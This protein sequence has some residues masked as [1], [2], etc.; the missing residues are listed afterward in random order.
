MLLR[1]IERRSQ[2]F[3]RNE[4]EADTPISVRVMAKWKLRAY[5]NGRYVVIVLRSAGCLQLTVQ[6]DKIVHDLERGYRLQLYD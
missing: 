2:V 6:A 4:A 1:Y 3:V 5:D